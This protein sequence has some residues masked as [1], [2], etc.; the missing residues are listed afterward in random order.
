MAFPTGPIDH[1]TLYT[2]EYGNVFRYDDI[3][4]SWEKYL[5]DEFGEPVL[6]SGA[7]MFGDLVQT[8]STTVR[9]QLAG[10][11]AINRV[12]DTKIQFRYMGSDLAPH[13]ADM[14][15]ACIEEVTQELVISSDSVV[16]GNVFAQFGEVLEAQ[17]DGE[18]VNGDQS[19]RTFMWERS[20]Q[21]GDAGLYIDT[22]T[23]TETYTVLESD[24]GK[25]LRRRDTWTGT[26]T[27]GGTFVQ[28]SN[29]MPVVFQL[30]TP[31]AYFSFE[32]F[33]GTGSLVLTLT[34]PA[35]VYQI[36]DLGAW[37][38][39]ENFTA[40]VRTIS[41]NDSS[42]KTYAFESENMTHF[43]WVAGDDNFDFTI[44]ARSLTPALNSL[45]RSF[46]N[47][48]NFNQNVYWLQTSNV[49]NMDEAFAN[50][51]K[52]NGSVNFSV[53]NITTA[54]A[55]FSN[56]SSFARS[57]TYQL[58]KIQNA[59]LMFRGCSEM[60][61]A[62]IYPGQDLTNASGMLENC[63]K[64]DGTISLK[65]AYNLA[66]SSKLLKN[67]SSYTGNND[68]PKQW[69][70]ANV[71]NGAAMFYGCSVFNRDISNQ[72][73]FRNMPKIT[74]AAYMFYGCR[75]FNQYQLGEWRWPAC[76]N[77]RRM[78]SGCYKLRGTFSNMMTSSATNLGGMFDGC[79]EIMG[80]GSWAP[81]LQNVEDMSSMF[82]SYQQPRL[83]GVRQW[84]T[85]SLKENGL[86]YFLYASEA[87]E[88]IDNWR[89]KNIPTR[90][91]GFANS[92]RMQGSSY[93]PEWGKMPP[94]FGWTPNSGGSKCGTIKNNSFPNRESGE[95]QPGDVLVP[96]YSMEGGDVTK[97]EWQR[98]D[99]KGNG[100]TH[101]NDS[102]A[103][104][105]TVGNSDRGYRLSCKITATSEDGGTATITTGS[106]TIAGS[107]RSR[108]SVTGYAVTTADNEK[109]ES[110]QVNLQFTGNDP[111]P[112]YKMG[113]E[114][115]FEFV[116]EM[117]PGSP[118]VLTLPE[119]VWS[120]EG[121]NM[122]SIDYSNSP[123]QT[124]ATQ[125]SDSHNPTGD[126]G[127]IPEPALDPSFPGYNP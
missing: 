64:F 88:P 61:S 3:T 31:T 51:S 53:S 39:V 13:G 91:T 55:A 21:I 97:W 96:Q 54:H 52:F 105:F 40:G 18:I 17:Q 126:L 67:C 122:T 45:Y 86:D 59:A 83:Y 114:G 9:P 15:F 20:D 24:R 90:P 72:S 99:S 57:F 111:I 38:S 42:R 125:H 109:G 78:F 98:F 33:G 80:L 121:A 79:Y 14:D 102:G 28:R 94:N 115:E 2:D 116:G 25:Y 41:F 12:D 36:D 77:Y 70:L 118:K 112:Y 48:P 23:T 89:A 74:N 82:A 32:K 26:G 93:T 110:V 35:L 81:H 124:T 10:E 120:W 117:L 68:S 123:E 49:S 58:P 4:G 92:Q 101:P 65:Q 44:D 56:C 37:E 95:G 47:Q 73:A 50:S 84:N 8:P 106:Y 22:G 16:E 107:N 100:G 119:G 104:E 62:K 11:L 34:G 127:S 75:A 43:Q 27:C 63:S 60:V 30:P 71:T 7:T 66:N 6:T 85:R 46:S 76:H 5:G 87:W 69:Q 29:P 113:D 1:G 108:S 19:A 103:R